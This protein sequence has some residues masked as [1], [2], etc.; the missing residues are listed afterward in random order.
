MIKLSEAIL[1]HKLKRNLGRKKERESSRENASPGPHSAL[2]IIH[3]RD[4]KVSN[5]FY[6]NED[7]ILPV[8]H[9]LIFTFVCRLRLIGQFGCRMGHA[10]TV[11]LGSETEV[12]WFNS[13]SS[14]STHSAIPPLAKDN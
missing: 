7:T 1:L 3:R 10:A 2:L 14:R 6:V 9:W 13:G 5:G 8:H 11:Y 4:F 12:T